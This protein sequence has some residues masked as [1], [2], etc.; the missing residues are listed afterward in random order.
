MVCAKGILSQL[1]PSLKFGVDR[2]RSMKR[3]YS[4]L[5]GIILIYPPGFHFGVVYWQVPAVPLAQLETPTVHHRLLLRGH[6]LQGGQNGAAALSW[7]LLVH[8]EVQS[9]VLIHFHV[10]V[11]WDRETGWLVGGIP[12][13]TALPSGRTESRRHTLIYTSPQGEQKSSLRPFLPSCA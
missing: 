9:A 12:K 10:R 3:T 2:D 8:A 1:T 11:L 7:P 5:F 6:G 4:N 13:A